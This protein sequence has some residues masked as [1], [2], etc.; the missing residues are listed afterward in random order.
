MPKSALRILLVTGTPRS[1]TTAVGKMLSLGRGVCSLH[2]PFNYHAGLWEIERYFEIPGTGSFS[3][4]KLD[5]CIQRIRS[6]DLGFKPG[7]FPEDQG[8]KKMLK[9]IV[10]SRARNSY[11]KC[12]VLPALSTIIWK[13]PFACFT[14][15]YISKAHGVDI[16][17]SVRN[18]WAVAASFKRMQWHFDLKDIAQR[19]RSVG[20][21]FGFELHQLQNRRLNSAVI[22]G[23]FLWQAVYSTVFD[24]SRSNER[25]IFVNVENIVTEPVET[26]SRLYDLL[27]LPW[28]DRVAARIGRS[29]RMGGGRDIPKGKRAHDRYRNIRAINVYWKHILDERERKAVGCATAKLWD[30]L[31]EGSL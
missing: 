18:P 2:E 29:Y 6:L 25:I 17:V 7:L 20:L 24:W 4:G 8:L 13:D 11:R 27:D 23:I 28:G 30:D 1:G 21:D 9:K 15:D 26:Y 14:A 12:R 5:L 31:K 3:Q 16:L 22:S 19:L 10:G